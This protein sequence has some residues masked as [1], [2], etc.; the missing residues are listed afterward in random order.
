M[1]YDCRS[2]KSINIIYFL[3]KRFDTF[4]DISNLQDISYMFQDVPP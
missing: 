4:F 3:D 1:F 2:L